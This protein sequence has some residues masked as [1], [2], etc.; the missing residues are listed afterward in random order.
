M[1]IFV[2]NYIFVAFINNIVSQYPLPFVIPIG[3]PIDL[4]HHV[5]SLMADDRRTHAPVLKAGSY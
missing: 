4:P 2:C 3:P 1:D 5:P